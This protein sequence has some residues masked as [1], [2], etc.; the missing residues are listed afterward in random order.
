MRQRE[1]FVIPT[2][3]LMMLLVYSLLWGFLKVNQKMTERYTLQR[4]YYQ[5]QIMEIMLESELQGIQSQL[6]EEFETTVLE[7]IQ[8]LNTNLYLN[9][10]EL[11]VEGS[12]QLQLFKNQEDIDEYTLVYHRVYAPEYFQNANKD[13]HWLNIGGELLDN[14]QVIIDNNSSLEIQFQ[15]YLDILLESEY[16]IEERQRLESPQYYDLLFNNTYNYHFN[17]GE[18]G[19]TTHSGEYTSY[20]RLNS[21]NFTRKSKGS[22]PLTNYQIE[23]EIFIFKRP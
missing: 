16:Q 8:T 5:T 15:R 11:V 18:V 22:L 23:S 6:I 1:G 2:V 4:S 10:S 7:K 19:I 9:T 21:P 13:Y 20:Y 3:L 17:V 14:S 12:P